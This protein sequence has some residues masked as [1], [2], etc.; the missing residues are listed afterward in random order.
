MADMTNYER[1]KNMSIE[2]MAQFINRTEAV[3][4]CSCNYTGHS[5]GNGSEP[6]ICISE[7]KKYLES[8]VK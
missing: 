8:E 5:C 1:I 2:E 3:P 7:I 6:E 4:C